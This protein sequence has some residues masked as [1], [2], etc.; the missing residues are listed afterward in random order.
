MS[1]IVFLK[2]QPGHRTQSP[3]APITPPSPETITARIDGMP[4]LGKI[5]VRLDANRILFKCAHYPA[6]RWIAAH[7]IITRHTG[8]AA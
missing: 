8:G 5:M 3:D 7:D 2:D 6:T 1:N 4:R